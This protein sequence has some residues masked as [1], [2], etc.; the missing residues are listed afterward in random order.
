MWEA[1]DEYLVKPFR[2]KENFKLAVKRVKDAFWSIMRRRRERKEAASANKEKG[3]WLGSM[4]IDTGLMQAAVKREFMNLM[5]L[6]SFN[7]RLL[8]HSPVN[9]T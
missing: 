3:A 1:V 2:S 6:G 4:G 9:E 7:S 5:M 8:R